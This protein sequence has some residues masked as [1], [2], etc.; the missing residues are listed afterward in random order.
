MA[1]TI[2]GQ[3]RER[4]RREVMAAYPRLRRKVYTER[5]EAW[6]KAREEFG[7]KWQEMCD[8]G[9]RLGYLEWTNEYSGSHLEVTTETMVDT[10]RYEFTETE[11]EYRQRIAGEI[12]R[13]FQQAK[14]DILNPPR[15][16]GGW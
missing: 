8:E 2:D 7:K 5:S 1:K 4:I 12:E 9:E 14:R 15:R 13:R 6:I 11:Q 3:L 16:R 10:G